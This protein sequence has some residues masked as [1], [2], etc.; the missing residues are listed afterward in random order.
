[1]SEA[2]VDL[3]LVRSVLFAPAGEERKLRNALAS[4]AD[5]VVADL[6]DGTAVGEKVAARTVVEAVW[7]D[8]EPRAARGLRVNA[9][10]SEWFDD[11]LELARRLPLDFL[12]LP[13]ATPE[14]VEALE[15]DGP[16]VLAIVETADGLRRAY[17][18]AATA[19][20]FAVALGSHDLA[21]ER[22]AT[23]S[24]TGPRARSK[25]TRKASARVGESSLW[26]AA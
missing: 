11:D 12:M 5:A 13:K 1:V 21:V 23:S 24:S 19:R 17:E 26:T 7:A 25:L 20:V 4:A 22:P 8:A 18:T 9:A 10:G 15:P 14:A 3:S 2:P 6:E 16:P